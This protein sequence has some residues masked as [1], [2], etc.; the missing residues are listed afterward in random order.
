MLIWM[1]VMMKSGCTSSIFSGISKIDENV[2][3]FA[4]WDVVH[5]PLDTTCHLIQLQL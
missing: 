3:V 4:T 1:K 5:R 2:V